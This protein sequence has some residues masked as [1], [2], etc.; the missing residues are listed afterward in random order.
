[1]FPDS[2]MSGNL[3]I[4]QLKILKNNPNFSRNLAKIPNL[5]DIKRK[6]LFELISHSPEFHPSTII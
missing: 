1:M 5:R 3:V 4:I 2:R 6:N